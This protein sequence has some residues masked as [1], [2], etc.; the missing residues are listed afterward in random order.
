MDCDHNMKKLFSMKEM[1]FKINVQPIKS[2]E[3]NINKNICVFYICMF[4]K[5]TPLTF[6]LFLS[7]VVRSS[8][9][10][11]IYLTFYLYEFYVF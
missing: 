6:H 11:C 2:D 9:L 4:E 5:K 7:G 8:S 3:K 1:A 10:Q